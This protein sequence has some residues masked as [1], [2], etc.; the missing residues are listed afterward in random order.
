M[1]VILYLFSSVKVFFAHFA[2]FTRYTVTCYRHAILL[3]QPYRGG[4]RDNPKG[5]STY[6]FYSHLL[7]TKRKSQ[8]SCPWQ[9][10]H[11]RKHSLSRSF[12]RTETQQPS[13]VWLCNWIYSGCDINWSE[14]YEAATILLS[15]YSKEAPTQN[16]IIIQQLGSQALSPFPGI[17][18]VHSQNQKVQTRHATQNSP[19][20]IIGTILLRV[21]RN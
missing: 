2:S 1:V 17:D 19:N 8:R 3:H 4:L 5:V 15:T 14:F 16:E 9:K 18:M 7:Q 12:K 13:F 20:K 21:R 10:K 11:S 6:L